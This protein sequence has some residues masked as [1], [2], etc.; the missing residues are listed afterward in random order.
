MD[1][2]G[3][4][5]LQLSNVSENNKGVYTVLAA[6]KAGIVEKNFEV[7]ILGERKW[8]LKKKMEKRNW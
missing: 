3:Y 1:D 8:T 4:A 7:K 5:I 6:N 2:D